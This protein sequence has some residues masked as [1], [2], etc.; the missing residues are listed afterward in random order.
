MVV[1]AAVPAI[2]SLGRV[3]AV[4]LVPLHLVALVEVRLGILID[5]PSEPR[6]DIYMLNLFTLQPF[7]SIPK[8]V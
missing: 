8:N 1:A 7:F 2:G 6:D 5:H 4:L 3:T